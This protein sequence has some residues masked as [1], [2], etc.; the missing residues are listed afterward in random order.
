MGGWIETRRVF[1]FTEMKG[2]ALG[3]SRRLIMFANITETLNKCRNPDSHGFV[4]GQVGMN[5]VQSHPESVWHFSKCHCV[6]MVSTRWKQL[7]EWTGVLNRLGL[8]V[9]GSAGNRGRFK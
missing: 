7:R 3:A 4:T 5:R 2:I 6:R 8:A 9:E 1:L